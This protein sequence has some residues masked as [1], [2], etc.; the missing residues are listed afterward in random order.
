VTGPAFGSPEERY[1]EPLRQLFKLGCIGGKS[2]EEV[3]PG[4]HV[5]SRSAQAGPSARAGPLMCLLSFL[6][7]PDSILWAK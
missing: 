7:P 4:A 2:S 3:S 6:A 5:T 1:S